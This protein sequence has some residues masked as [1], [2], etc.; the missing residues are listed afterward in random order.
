MPSIL[1][2]FKEGLTKTREGFVDEI[3]KLVKNKYA[4][5]DELLEQI[6]EILIAADVGVETSLGIIERLKTY[7]NREG[8]QKPLQLISILKEQLLT[9]LLESSINGKEKAEDDFF[10]P[11]INPFVVMV[12]GVNGTGK[13]TTI[14]KL[15]KAFH[16]HG[17]KVLLAAADTFRAA[18]SEQLEIWAKRAKVDIVRTQPG[19]DP[20]SVAFDAL[21]A[22]LA[23]NV[24]VLIVD[25][26]G[27]LHTKVNLM[28]ELKKIH[29]V[30]GKAMETAPHEVLLVIDATTGQN[31]L[32][33]ARQFK[34]AVA[35]TGIVVTK[36]DGTAKGGMVFAI[37]NQLRVP[38]R[39]VGFGEKLDDLKP[40]DPKIYVEALFL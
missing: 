27:R 39:F 38:V 3:I 31:A 30:L 10:N 2:K 35:V 5:D 11:K 34:E 15:A 26:A 21:R 37:Q 18:A 6:E 36:L 16:D 7:V 12:V 13:T 22:V 25:T 8:F 33:Q 19:G 24:E 9:Y 17:K 23:R 29:R 28:E 1:E 14:A 20:A 4:I 32:N 40:F